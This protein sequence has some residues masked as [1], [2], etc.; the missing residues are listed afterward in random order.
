[1]KTILGISAAALLA[2][3]ATAAEG[4]SNTQMTPEEIQARVDWVNEAEAQD[5]HFWRRWRD[6]PDQTAFRQPQTWYNPMIL[7]DG[8]VSQPFFPRAE[9][10]EPATIDPEAIAAASGYAMER[11]TQAF[12]I[13]HRGKIRHAEFM[14]GFHES[15]PI[16]SHSWVKTL[17]GIVAGFALADGDIES[18]DD[19]VENYIQEWKGDPRGQ[20]TV[21]QVLHNTTGLELPFGE[22]GQGPQPY[23]KSMQ[24]VE[25]TDIFGT[26]LSFELV[27]EPGKTFAHNNPNTQLAGMIIH[28]ATGKNFAH[29]LGEKLW[30][31]MGAQRGAMRLDGLEGNVISYCCFLSAPA[32]WMRVAHLLM[33]DGRLPDGTQLLPDGW[34]DEMLTGSEPNPNYGFQIWTDTVH[35]ERRPYYPSMPPNFANYHSEPFATDDLF[36]LDGGG[37]VRVWISPGLE[38][39]VLRMG[40]PP[41]RDKGFDEAFIP[42]MI[43]RG[44]LQVERP[45]E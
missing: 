24:L 11:E 2:V 12:M 9:P 3:G 19:P 8:G 45:P 22:R 44:I 27:D 5:F 40:Y 17:H 21:R 25:G 20:I 32:D 29:Y 37:K 13:Y 6:Q 15:S 41:P 30:R 28:R 42:N 31:P 1:M 10:G 23:S 38:L 39:I 14:E 7:V 16:S 36:Y 33:K 34:V 35:M 18:L 4:Q 43:I 26:V